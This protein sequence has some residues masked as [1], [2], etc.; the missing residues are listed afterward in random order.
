MHRASRYDGAVCLWSQDGAS[1]VRVTGLLR[2]GGVR[3]RRR[4]ASIA[5]PGGSGPHGG[6]G[7]R[8]LE[9]AHD[10]CR[11]VNRFLDQTWLHQCLQCQ[12][13]GRRQSH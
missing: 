4:A 6:N 3:E 11:T 13:H 10:P 5:P 9:P 8:L 12:L 7:N 1:R 2:Y